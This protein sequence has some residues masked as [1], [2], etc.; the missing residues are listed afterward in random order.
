MLRVTQR[1]Q[2]SCNHL[3][4]R[5]T[6]VSPNL[7]WGN[8]GTHDILGPWYPFKETKSPSLVRGHGYGCHHWGIVRIE[9][10]IG[11]WKEKGG[12]SRQRQRKGANYKEIY[13]MQH[14]SYSDSF[15]TLQKA[16]SIRQAPHEMI[17][18]SKNKLKTPI[19]TLWILVWCCVFSTTLFT[20]HPAW[21][22]WW[23]AFCPLLPVIFPAW[24]TRVYLSPTHGLFLQLVQSSSTLHPCQASEPPTLTLVPPWSLALCPC[25]IHKKCLAWNVLALQ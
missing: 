16:K 8:G 25:K 23:C 6:R 21:H 18:N 4:N 11:D 12:T 7:W 9:K 1:Q 10:I 17:I 2:I 13:L 3:L 14:G 19:L 20:Y 22:G 5:F 15:R 24:S